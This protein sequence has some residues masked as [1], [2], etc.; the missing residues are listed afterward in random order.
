MRASRQT[1]FTLIELMVVVAVLAVLLAIAVPS[2]E[3]IIN[4]SR[5]TSAA[6]ELVASIQT[7]RMGSMR[8]N[9]RAVVCLSADPQ[10]A[11]P[12]CGTVNPTGWI[13]FVDTN[14][15]GL[16]DAPS[17]PA[18]ATDDTLLRVSTVKPPMAV[19]A[20]PATAGKLVFR[21]DGLARDNTGGTLSTST[22]LNGTVDVCLPTRRPGENARHI[23]VLSGSSVSVARANTNA[24]CNAPA[25]PSP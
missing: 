19:S 21:S 7:A 11:T 17:S 22:L 20:S 5:L 1:G 18:V 2:F 12:A 4:S 10:A 8:H 25:N 6:N 16:F 3:S 24:T 15:N 9:R 14:G 13:T 23:N